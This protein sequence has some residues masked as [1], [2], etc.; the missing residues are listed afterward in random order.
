MASLPCTVARGGIR[1]CSLPSQMPVVVLTQACA[2]VSSP[3]LPPTPKCPRCLTPRFP[4]QG[5]ALVEYE[6]KKE[7]Q[8]AIDTMNGADLLGQALVVDWAFTKGPNKKGGRGRK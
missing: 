6:G 4:T 8:E 5:Y 3:S 1:V 2:K 7:A